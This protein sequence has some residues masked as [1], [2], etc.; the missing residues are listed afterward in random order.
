MTMAIAGIGAG[1]IAAFGIS[2]VLATLLFGVEPRDPLTFAAVT[3]MLF[4]VAI[5]ACLL[6]A[7]KASRV[8]PVIA[9]RCE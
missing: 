2:R 3:A 9:L 5:A 1:L 4:A 7:L 8:D 6:P